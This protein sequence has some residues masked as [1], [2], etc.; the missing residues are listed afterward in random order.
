M[1]MSP[2][3]LPLLK[4]SRVLTSGGELKAIPRNLIPHE[5]MSKEEKA[6]RDELKK[7]L[8]SRHWRLNNLYYIVDEKGHKRKFRLN[9][10][11][12]TLLKNLWYFNI[13]LKAR[14]LGMTTFICILF[15]DTA[16]FRPSTHC[17]IIAHN[18]EDAEE[19]FSNK[20]RFAYDNLPDWFKDELHAPS[21][22]TKKLAFS[23]GSSIRVGTSLRSGT[24]YMLHICL[25]GDTEVFVKDGFTKNIK[26][27][28][29]GDMVM[30]SRGSYQEVKQLI[31]NRIEDVG[32]PLISIKTFGNYDPIKATG[33]HSILCRPKHGKDCKKGV[34]KQANEIVP[35][36]Y[37]AFPI[38]EPSMKLKNN[39]LPLD[40]YRGKERVKVDFDLGYFIGLY[41]AEGYIR[42]SQCVIAGDRKEDQSRLKKISKLKYLYDSLSVYHSNTS[43]TSSIN[44]NG[45][46]FCDFI[47]SKFNKDGDK[48]IPDCVWGWGRPFLDGLIRGYFDGDGSY[49]NVNMVQVTS[50]RRQLIDQMKLLIMSLRFG[51]PSIYHR[52]AGE[53]YGRNCKETWVLKMYGPCNWKFREYFKLELPPVNTMIGK[54]RLAMGQRPG[55]KKLWRRG[56]DYYWAR[57][58]SC[59][60]APDEEFVYDI[61][62]ENS[63]HN[64]V[65]TSGVVHNSEFGKI[66]A[67]FPAKAQEIVTGGLNTV[68]AGQYV[69][70][71]STAEGREGYFYKFCMEAKHR[72]LRGISPNKLQFK[73]HFFPWWKDPRYHLEQDQ[74]IN[75][76]FTKYFEDLEGKGIHLSRPQ[77][78]WYLAKAETQGE[79][80]LREFPAT[81]EEAFNA[82]IVGAYYSSQMTLIRKQKRIGKVSHDP[83]YPV[84]VFWDIGFNDKMALWFHQRIGVQNRL[85]RYFEGSGEGLQYYVEYMNKLP[86]VYGTHYMPHDGGNHSPQ[87]GETFEQYARKLGLRDIRIIPRAKNQDEVQ[88]GIQAVRNFLGTTWI[89]EELCDTGIK[90][91]DN[92]RKEW[93][94]NLGEFKRSPLH[95]KH[96]NGA[97]SLRC[98]AVGFK[99]LVTAFE[100]DLLPE[101][102]YDM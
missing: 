64:Y 98:G 19:F 67:R 45:R 97:D 28:M 36:D 58:I 87:T 71:E 33:N 20:I 80:L 76:E 59:D 27:I 48:Y 100:A 14:Q 86:Y 22:S 93:D 3:M 61:A 47:V 72:L 83:V 88:K 7:N 56:A 37:I 81:P 68:H 30:N 18:R 16:L 42:G 31:K 1:P 25:S 74:P 78:N 46:K 52:P 95:D 50:T 55:G 35:G 39:D 29:P 17:G 94:P 85:I 44:I 96:S 77:K 12:S 79:D 92:Y 75:Q 49:L 73:F 11:Q 10:A 101:Y 21:D 4:K 89:D 63:P 38:R 9:W 102:A 91:L 84:N 62:L 53:Y 54:L 24:F 69:F 65:T 90:C 82:S 13:I 32:H 57:V 23:N 51:Y 66:C 99:A 15:L 8:T 40:G 70:I 6:A 34:W 5:H 60:I 26:D 2:H 41:L 43:E